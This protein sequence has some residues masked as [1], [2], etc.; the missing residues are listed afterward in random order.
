MFLANA[1]A[2]KHLPQAD[3]ILA[4]NQVGELVEQG[5]FTELNVAGNYIYNLQV[6]LEESSHDD[7]DGSTTDSNDKLQSQIPSTTSVADESRKTGD[8]TIYKYY[9]RA[10]GPWSMVG[11]VALVAVNEA[12][13]G[14]ASKFSIS[15]SPSP[16]FFF[17]FSRRR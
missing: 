9:V 4:L 16:P 3:L 15:S 11:F 14:V 10:L 7:K 2:V 13:F 5:N 1:P 12:F 8:W 6:K 17:F